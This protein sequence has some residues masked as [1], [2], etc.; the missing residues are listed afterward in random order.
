[1]IRGKRKWFVL[2]AVIVAL[3]AYLIVLQRNAHESN[4]RTLRLSDDVK[5]IDQVQVF[6]IVSDVNAA[7]RQLTAQL[8]FKVSGNIARDEFT[9]RADLK[10][11]LNNIGV[12]QEFDFPKET[13]WPP[14]RESSSR[15]MCP[16]PETRSSLLSISS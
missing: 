10:L 9:P 3:A 7:T 12:Q 11:L 2:F 8:S 13:R 4:L 16:V 6:I 1:M 5:V 14:S 15:V